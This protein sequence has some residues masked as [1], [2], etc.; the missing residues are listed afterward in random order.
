MHKHLNRSVMGMA[1]LGYGVGAAAWG[2][3][4]SAGTESKPISA[5]RAALTANAVDAATPGFIQYPALSPDGS[6]I[7]FNWLGDLWAVAAKGGVA[8]RL[9]SSPADDQRANFSPD[10]SSIAF[11]S[12]RDGGR[13]IYVMQVTRVE[14]GGL[15]TGPV[16]R[17][18]VSDKP[19][20][21][22]SGGG[23]WTR[24]G[25][26]LAF[27]ERAPGIYRGTQMFVAPLTGGPTRELTAAYGGSPRVSA[28]G[29]QLVFTRRRAEYT[30][31]RYGGPGA[32]DLWAMDMKSGSFT[33]LTSDARSEGD[34]FGLPDGSVVYV[35]TRDGTC[36]IYRMAKGGS[37]ASATQLTR[38]APSAGEATIGHGVRD[39]SVNDR[40]TVASFCVWD[41]LYTLDLTKPGAAPSAVDV[42][43]AVDLNDV[44]FQRLNLARE[45]SEQA[46]SP[47]GKTIAVIARGEVFVRSTEENRPTRRVT[48]TPGRETGLAWSPDGRVLW[49]ASDESGTSRIYYATVSLA[50]EDILPKDEK[51]EDDKKKDEEK[52]DGAKAD[53]PKKDDAAAAD[54]P[55]KKD[56]NA[57]ADGEKK[58]DGGKPPAGKERKP[59]FAKRWSEGLRFDV[60]RLD[61]ALVGAGANDG[62]LGMELRSPNPSPDGRKLIVTRGLGDMVLIDLV[63]KQSRLLMAGWNEAEVQWASDSRQIVFA[64]EDLDFNSDVFLL[65]TAENDKGEYAEPVNITRHP[66]LDVSPR[67]SRDGKVLYFLTERD[68]ENFQFAVW[69]VYLDQTLEAMPAYELEDYFKKQATA[70]KA[71]KPIA[72]VLWD[73]ADWVSKD[74][75]KPA[76]TLTI[77]T[78]NAHMRVRKVLSSTGS[79][80]NLNITPGGDRVIVSAPADAPGPGAEGSLVSVSYKGDDK[81]VVA[82]G[83][84]G[85]VSVSP[86]G[87]RVTFVKARQAAGTALTGGAGGKVD[88]YAVDAP[89]VL[90]VKQAQR[91]KFLEAA[92][93]VGNLFY[94]PTLKGLDWKKLTERYL[95][96]AESTRTTSEFNRVYSLM[97]GELDGSHL[98]IMGGPSTFTPPSLAVGSLALDAV[99]VENGW[100]VTRLLFNSP[101]GKGAMA[102]KAGDIITHIEDRA[103]AGKDLG[104]ALQGTSG[105][106][107]LVTVVRTEAASPANAAGTSENVNAA[108][109]QVG[110][111]TL[112]LIVT[113]VSSGADSEL[114]YLDE[115]NRRAEIV[116]KTSGG[117]LGYLHIKAM[118]EASVRDF[119]RDL[120]A[121]AHGKEGLV[122][123]VRD[124]GGGSTADILLTSLTAP[125]HAYTV[126]RGADGATTPKDSYPRD[127][128][129]IYG[130]SRP[131]TVMINENSFSNAEIFAHSIKTIGR[132]KLVGTQTYGG[133]IST[134]AA[135]LVDG[136]AVRT[137]F[138]G[139]YLPSG[140]DMESNGAMPDFDVPSLPQ[141]EAA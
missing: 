53:E 11:E 4:V 69:G 54:K 60:H 64:R 32:S 66:D 38:F 116:D 99:P 82:S 57:A 49:F 48:F 67:L 97:L 124:N 100:K 35:A 89:V 135:T 109:D 84:A 73:D 95:S 47:D 129:L 90:D 106:E 125:V 141:D 56:D 120:Y 111:R 13:S 118:G 96:L 23:A 112:T 30:R 79:L 25:A 46:L 39:L 55:E 94:H 133:V 17:V 10:G 140:T 22:P 122:I 81:K 126:P 102:L 130:Y 2:C 16:R 80:S 9:T 63:K 58:D 21:L 70:A 18:T 24:D 45:V 59:D 121:A 7:V 134:G 137:P 78:A 68:G 20:V 103:T 127:R 107:T 27:T 5:P 14:G 77:D 138:R 75:H 43:T 83:S 15:T 74:K 91:Q 131:I 110:P 93:I 44:D 123:D 6:T 33:Q 19:Q 37:E 40:G 36:N 85:N 117:R 105:R 101:L 65:D 12:D 41:T 51:K 62:V 61:D 8:T 114:R 132:G 104:W 139:W 52:K 28:D 3:A 108:P 72:P 98:G 86:S 76:K 113:P 88:T 29:T 92:R 119:E 1:L 128:R 136:T 115:V 34:G 42:T 87:D 31:P 71:I 50:R 26:S